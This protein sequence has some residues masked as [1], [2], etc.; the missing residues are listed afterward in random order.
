[1][2]PASKTGSRI[3]VH[4][5]GHAIVAHELGFAVVR[6]EIDAESGFCDVRVPRFLV[7]DACLSVE[8]GPF[9]ALVGWLIVLAAGTISEGTGTGD[10]AIS[11]WVS[12]VMATFERYRGLQRRP[13]RAELVADACRAGEAIARTNMDG[14]LARRLAEATGAAALAIL[15]ERRDRVD[16]LAAVLVEFRVLQRPSLVP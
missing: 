8:R 11:E 5:G 2:F 10:E 7:A 14:P 16:A 13:A 12:A 4:E 6:V 15:C 3:A 9:D 1:M